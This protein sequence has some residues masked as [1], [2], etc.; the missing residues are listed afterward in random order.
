MNDL[1]KFQSLPRFDLS[2]GNHLNE[3][4]RYLDVNKDDLK[5][6]SFVW[7]KSLGYFST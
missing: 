4:I 1:R 7:D 5:I 6:D 3:S 2:L